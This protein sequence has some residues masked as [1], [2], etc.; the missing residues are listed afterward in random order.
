LRKTAPDFRGDELILDAT[1]AINQPNTVT[2]LQNT[3]LVSITYGYLLGSVQDD[4]SH[5]MQ[6]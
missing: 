5:E 1:L 6:A 2:I 3:R 4:G